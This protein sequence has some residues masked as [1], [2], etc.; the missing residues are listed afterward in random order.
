M[1]YDTS[2]FPLG[3][4]DPRVL[5]TN[6]V[7]MDIAMNS[8]DQVSWLDRGPLRAPL[9]RKTWYGIEQQVN[10]FLI[11]TAF[12][13]VPLIYVDGSELV[14]PSPSKLIQRDGNLYS[15]RLPASFPVTLS[16]NWAADEPLLTVRSDQAL[17]QQ[18]AQPLGSEMIG[19]GAGTVETALVALENRTSE[20]ESDLSVSSG[21]LRSIA[22]ESRLNYLTNISK[23]PHRVIGKAS[24]ESFYDNFGVMDVTPTGELILLFRRGT[25]HDGG[26]DGKI[27]FRK[28]MA[29]GEW[30]PVTIV[31]EQQG[32]DFRAA[33]GGVMPS[34]RIVVSGT[35]WSTG[36]MYIYTSDDY[37][38]TW[39]LRQIVPK[40]DA[41]YRLSY[42][43]AIQV[44]AKFVLPY[45]MEVGSVTMLRW[46][47]TTDGGDTWI[48]G[49]TIYSGS[50]NYN[51]AEYANLGGGF[52]FGVSRK[53]TGAGGELRQ[54]L[55]RDGGT[56]WE[57]R[58]VVASQNGDGNSVIVS[59]SISVVNNKSGTPYLVLFY[60]NRTTEACY[61][62]TVPVSNVIS[63][64][65]T[66]SERNQV[67]SA[68]SASGYTS[69]VVFDGC[70][71]FGNIYR[72]AS[73]TKCGA[74][75][76]ELYLGGLPD[77]ETDWVSV[78]AS[79]IYSFA[80]GLRRPPKSVVVLFAKTSNPSAWYVV[81]PTYFNDGSNRG[82][83]AQVEIGQ[84]T[85]RVG[86]GAAVWGTAYFG[87]IDN[88]TSDRATSGYYKI[89][90]FL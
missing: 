10:D 79:S 73:A 88:S 69:Q 25:V 1:A 30:G 57:D 35:I 81:S 61:Y 90:A 72:E 13:P 41:N 2:A 6:A 49:A 55:S 71:V 76:F 74:Y 28:L 27:A 20:I 85:I 43:K 4:K 39:G 65:I 86:T 66:W 82:S 52:V 15:V 38:D 40:G 18:L 75:Q 77:F 34:G 7:N 64:A 24:V 22:R 3:S 51:E 26:S 70:R 63:G 16:G 58:G 14:V 44:G 21:A 19:R 17:R 33:G 54:F 11:G 48:E 84:S 87:G 53:Y 62:R 78:S 9:A 45:Y 37:G 29:S 80:H 59:P 23:L 31:A 89:Q 68:P 12:E 42:G 47:E 8:L 60:T 46:L 50:I 83:G 67:Y 36:D 5:Y 56:T 32:Q